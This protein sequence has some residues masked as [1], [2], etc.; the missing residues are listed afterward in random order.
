MMGLFIFIKIIIILYYFIIIIIDFIS[1]IKNKLL[2]YKFIS[3]FEG[4][5]NALHLYI[6]ST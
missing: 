6:E 4:D 2:L 3:E 1:I 5:G